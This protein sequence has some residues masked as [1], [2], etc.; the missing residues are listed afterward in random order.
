MGANIK[1]SKI[2][3][4]EM[5]YFRRSRGVTKNGHVKKYH[6]KGRTEVTILILL[7]QDNSAVRDICSE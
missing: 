6:N 2:K 5:K 4:V 1:K 3:A 7:K